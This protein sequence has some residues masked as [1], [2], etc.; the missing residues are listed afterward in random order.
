MISA[1]N[2]HISFQ[3]LYPKPVSTW[4]H[5]LWK[6]IAKYQISVL[7]RWVANGSIGQDGVFLLCKQGVLSDLLGV[8]SITY[9]RIWRH[10][11][12][13]STVSR[14]RRCRWRC[15]RACA[16]A[17]QAGQG[18][19]NTV[20]SEIMILR[21][22]IDSNSNIL[23]IKRVETTSSV[24]SHRN[25]RTKS[26]RSQSSTSK[27]THRQ[28]VAMVDLLYSMSCRRIISARVSSP[29]SIWSTLGVGVGVRYPHPLPC[30]MPSLRARRQALGR[31]PRAHPIS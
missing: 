3:K 6:I 26:I 4:Q 31:E 19:R 5:F 25:Q 8:R 18:E 1:R 23:S 10:G 2:P 20:Q 11:L 14:T 7:S 12:G 30:H 13:G 28:H 9:P 24:C 15:L 22:D 29:R 17:H 16:P 21:S 27:T